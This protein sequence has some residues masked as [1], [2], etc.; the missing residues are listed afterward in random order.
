MGAY[1]SFDEA[2]DSEKFR[3]ASW[4]NKLGCVQHAHK[5]DEK[6][7]DTETHTHV[8]FYNRECGDISEADLMVALK[9]YDENEFYDWGFSVITSFVIKEIEL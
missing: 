5:D 8:V 1:T 9:Y 7:D 4:G 2:L 6:E 3:Y